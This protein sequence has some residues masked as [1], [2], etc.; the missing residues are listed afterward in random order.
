[1]FVINDDTLVFISVI[2]GFILT[3]FVLKLFVIVNHLDRNKELKDE[4]LK[5]QT[6]IAFTKEEIEVLDSK[7]KIKAQQDEDEEDNTNEVIV[8]FSVAF[9][10]IVLFAVIA[11]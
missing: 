9:F 7:A 3:I 1:M 2:I 6:N 5:I 11:L 4:R 10:L 8:Y